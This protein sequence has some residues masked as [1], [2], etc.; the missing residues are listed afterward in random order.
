VRNNRNV[1][2]GR[3]SFV[4]FSGRSEA[5]AILGDDQAYADVATMRFAR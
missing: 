3:S 1:F 5:F 2:C 4:W